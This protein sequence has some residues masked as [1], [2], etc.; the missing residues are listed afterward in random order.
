MKIFIEAQSQALDEMPPRKKGI[1]AILDKEGKKY[2]KQS[3]LAAGAYN[4]LHDLLS[5][6]F[7]KMKERIAELEKERD[8]ILIRENYYK[9]ELETKK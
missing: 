2:Y 8:R 3:Q 1:I 9:K 4:E 6:L 7:G 5:P